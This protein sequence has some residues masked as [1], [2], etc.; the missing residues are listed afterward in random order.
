MGS[1]NWLGLARYE[2]RSFKLS[3]YTLCES[4]LILCCCLQGVG[5]R[6]SM[7]VCR[8]A[9]VDPNKRAGEMTDEEVSFEYVAICPAE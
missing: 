7:V 3:I 1:V 4:M 6:Y 8:K 9:D 2:G 5:R